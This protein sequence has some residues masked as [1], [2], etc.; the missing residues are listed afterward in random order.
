M[1]G[2]PQGRALLQ[3]LDWPGFVAVQPGDYD[4]LGLIADKLGVE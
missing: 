4:G 1:S 2:N 3:H